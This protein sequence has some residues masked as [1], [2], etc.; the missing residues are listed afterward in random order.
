MTASHLILNIVL[1]GCG[2]TV[3]MDIWLMFL[4]R[5][6]VP[7]LNFAFL[8]RWVGH[9]IR[10]QAR[11]AAIGKA[12]PI[13]HEVPLGWITHYAIGIVFAGLLIV[14]A[15]VSWMVAPSVGVAVLTGVGTV[16]FPLLVMQP[17]IGQGVAAAKTAAPLKNCLRSLANHTVFGLGLFLAA[18]VIEW[19]AR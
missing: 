11:H 12:S 2:A 1:I 14:L 19:V 17:A 16:V 8:G 9:L 10:G 5:I 13:A 18:W 3:I 4:K 6:G 15:G 7:T